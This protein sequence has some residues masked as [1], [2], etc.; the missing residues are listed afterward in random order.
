MGFQMREIWIIKEK[1]ECV[2]QGKQYKQSRKG[3]NAHV[4]HYKHT[5]YG[6]ERVLDKDMT[7]RGVWQSLDSIAC[8]AKTLKFDSGQEGTTNS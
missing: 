7:G 8:Q 3:K 6:R 1:R 5:E 4:E 2:Q